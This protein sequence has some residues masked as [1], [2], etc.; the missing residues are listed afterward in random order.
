MIKWGT[1]GQKSWPR[2][3]FYT[4]PISLKSD[5]VFDIGHNLC[6]PHFLI[7]MST[8]IL[9]YLGFSIYP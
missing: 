1:Y 3:K 6:I 8:I 4:F 5:L 7:A 2:Y 9:I